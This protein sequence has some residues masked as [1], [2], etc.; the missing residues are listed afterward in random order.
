MNWLKFETRNPEQGRRNPFP[1]S[2]FRISSHLNPKIQLSSGALLS[3]ARGHLEKDITRKLSFEQS[4]NE[5]PSMGS[6]AR[7][8]SRAVRLLGFGCVLNC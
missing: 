3:T 5:A 2:Q 8:A 7:Q 4:G 1:R 6:L